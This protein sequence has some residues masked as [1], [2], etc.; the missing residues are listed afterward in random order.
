MLL[1]FKAMINFQLIIYALISDYPSCWSHVYDQ[2]K[3]NLSSNSWLF[4]LFMFWLMIAHVVEASL[5][6][7]LSFLCFD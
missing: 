2:F 5:V 6:V 7:R 4:N 1:L 3:L